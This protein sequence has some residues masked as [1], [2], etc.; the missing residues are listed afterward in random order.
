[1]IFECD[2]PECEANFSFVVY[3]AQYIMCPE[4]KHVFDSVDFMDFVSTIA[5]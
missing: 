5:I 2:C 3:D 4:C 1:M